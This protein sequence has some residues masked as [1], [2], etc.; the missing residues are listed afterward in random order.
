MKK[1]YIIPTAKVITLK[2]CQQILTSSVTLVD[3]P[4]TPPT[5]GGTLAPEFDLL[6]QSGEY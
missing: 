5:P 6:Q 2:I 3:E 4:V 1:N